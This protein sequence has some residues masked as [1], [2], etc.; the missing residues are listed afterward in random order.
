MTLRRTLTALALCVMALTLFMGCVEPGPPMPPRR[1]WRL[2]R[3]RRAPRF[4]LSTFPAWPSGKAP[5]PPRLRLAPCSSMMKCK[6]WRSVRAG[7][8]WG[9]CVVIGSAGPPCATC[10]PYRLTGRNPCP[11]D[12]SAGSGSQGD[13]PSPP[14]PP[15]PCRGYSPGQVREE[16]PADRGRAPGVTPGAGQDLKMGRNPSRRQRTGA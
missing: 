2:R 16:P 8:G 11:G 1:W 7:A 12:A 9:M 13:H 6:S 14:N 10:S 15:R 3:R 5:P 4:I